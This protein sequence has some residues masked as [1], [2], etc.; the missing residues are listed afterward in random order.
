MGR[1]HSA[2]CAGPSARRAFLGPPGSVSARSPS[3]P[4][5]LHRLVLLSP[6]LLS[7]LQTQRI[8]SCLSRPGPMPPPPGSPHS[9]E[10]KAVSPSSAKALCL[11]RRPGLPSPPGV[12]RG[13]SAAR[14]G[15]S[16]GQALGRVN[17]HFPSPQRGLAPGRHTIN[18]CW[19]Q[20]IFPFIL[21]TFLFPSFFPSFLP[22]SLFFISW[23]YSIVMFFRLI[24]SI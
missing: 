2:N 21:L 11:P 19:S 4:L 5:P 12:P 17:F 20:C 3:L 23:L 8:P 22:P 10:P 24:K 15:A 1:I 13:W 9:P 6:A 7:G 14:L 18:T 16:C